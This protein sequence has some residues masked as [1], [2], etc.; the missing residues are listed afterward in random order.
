MPEAEATSVRY[1]SGTF[2]IT[3]PNTITVT[4]S[5]S[6][7]AD[8]SDYTGLRISDGRGG[9]LV[10]RSVDSLSGPFQTISYFGITTTPSQTHTLRFSGDPVP[11]SATGRINVD[12][13]YYYDRGRLFTGD[14]VRYYYL[15]HSN[16]LVAD[17]Q[18]PSLVTSPAARAPRL[19]L[20]RADLTLEFNERMDASRTAAGNIMLSCEARPGSGSPSTIDLGSLSGAALPGADSDSLVL[21]LTPG[22][23]ASIISGS[24][25]CGS[26]WHASLRPSALFDA[27]GNALPAVQRTALAVT[28]DTQPPRLGDPAASLD[29]ASGTLAIHFTEYVEAG[30]GALDGIS[31][32]ASGGRD[33][34]A[35]SGASLAVSGETA[36]VAL[37]EE[38]RVRLVEVRHMHGQLHLDAARGSF[39]DLAGREFAGRTGAQIDVQPDAS[40]PGLQAGAR[41]SLDLNTGSLAFAFNESVRVQDASLAGARILDADSAPI[42]ILDGL[43][44]LGTDAYS[45]SVSFSLNRTLRADAVG[46]ARI[47]V[48]AG[49]FA[50]AA[51]NDH[52]GL[53]AFPLDVTADYARPS[54][55]QGRAPALDYN[56][57]LFSVEL[58]EYA[59]KVRPWGIVLRDAS[60]TTSIVLGGADVLPAPEGQKYSDIVAVNLTLRDAANAL[61]A[62]ASFV[63]SNPST[64]EDLSGN[65]FAGPFRAELNVTEDGTPPALDGARPPLLNMPRRTLAVSFTEYVNATAV[66]A[67]GISIKNSTSLITTLGGATPQ[68]AHGDIVVINLTTMQ[69]AALSPNSPSRIDIAAG[70]F[71]DL[72]G[73]AIEAV[74]D[75]GIQTRTDTDPPRLA[76]GQT[77]A[78]DLGLLTLTVEFSEPVNAP[79]IDLSGITIVGASG[80][81]RTHL[82]GA[83]LPD[84]IG[85]S[86]VLGI[87]ADQRASVI[88]AMAV[89]G[90]VRIAM[91]PSAVSDLAGN[92]FA[93]PFSSELG[94]TRDTEPPGVNASR[95]PLLD[96]AAGMLTIWFDEHINASRTDPTRIQ[97]VGLHTFELSSESAPSPPPPG[98]PP[99]LSAVLSLTPDQKA[100]AVLQESSRV[101]STHSGAF[102]DLSGNG[103]PINMG[104]NPSYVGS[105]DAGFALRLIE[106]RAAPAMLVGGADAPLLN[107]SDGTLTVRLDE[108]VEIAAVR[109]GLIEIGGGGGGGNP[110]R[111]PLESSAV[112]DAACRGPCSMPPPSSDTVVV[113]LAPHEKAAAAGADRIWVGRGAF[114]DLSSNPIAAQDAALKR[115]PGHGAPRNRLLGRG[116][117]ACPW[118][119]RRRP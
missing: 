34:E 101:R 60:G 80:G 119:G 59:G 72:S 64:F 8:R 2:K 88:A 77:P 100:D 63:E 1:V 16:V 75:R 61:L 7:Y 107:L 65:L 28:G 86:A 99:P 6:I 44:P 78:L 103:M 26:G 14:D 22:Q 35:L 115:D 112:L 92:A 98:S 43:E 84:S 76:A 12:Q 70:A 23:K 29:L 45:T 25:R 41:P 102:Y 89:D 33:R 111:I 68:A 20:E 94:I 93:G 110:S 46:A 74:T 79:G 114:T 27:G 67:G 96:L 47:T 82:A 52:P 49:A 83:S 51:R 18:A 90:P 104:N 37:T 69:V 87:T 5:H 32:G 21:R 38:Q 19:D 105:P 9:G 13:L 53:S 97:L 48:P 116:R 71:V 42:A 36:T 113:R 54:V 10:S 85:S 62:N 15:R 39:S 4:F 109:T 11:T 108:H 66:S 3:G 56:T 58:D 17:G 24:E 55:A 106:D 40:P 73:N 117:R 30:A 118:P 31:V 95:P 81:N 91:L 50:D 57:G